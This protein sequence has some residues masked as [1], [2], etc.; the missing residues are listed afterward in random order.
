[1]GTYL[2]TLFPRLSKIRI[3]LSRDQLMLLMAAVNEI[4]LGIDIYLAHLLSGTIVLREWIPI[5]FGPV[6]GILLIF[7]GW[8]AGK[9]HLAA[10]WIANFI[11][12][13]SILVGLL[14]TYFH[15]TRAILPTGP[16]GSKITIQMLIWAP[17]VIGPLVFSLVGLLGITAIWKEEPA[18]SGRLVL[19]SG[20]AIQF[21][22]NKTRAFFL[23]V[24][25]GTLATLI[26]SVLDH[27][28]TNFQNPWLWVPVAAGVLGVITSLILALLEKPKR[29]DLLVYFLVMGLLILVGVIGAGLH[30]LE[31]LTSRSEFVQERFIRGAPFLAPLLFANMG[32]LGLINLFDPA[33]RE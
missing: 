22:F 13:S 11:F 10:V 30:I 5:V 9:K 26:S 25:L 31:N 33:S 14:G 6:A 24:S 23:M 4:F 20:K 21:P 17:P 32:T 27:A 29:G 2:E 15:F 19:F 7:A 3:P 12:V 18:N 28:R 1:M 8:L 16:V